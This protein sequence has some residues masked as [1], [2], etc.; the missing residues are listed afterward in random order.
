[1]E[2]ALLE[3]ILGLEKYIKELEQENAELKEEVQE[4]KGE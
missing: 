3:E 4:L 1:M 2:E